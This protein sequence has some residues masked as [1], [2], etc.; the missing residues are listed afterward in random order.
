MISSAP[1]R[2]R[3]RSEP[4]WPSGLIAME[5]F[6]SRMIFPSKSTAGMRPWR[7][8]CTRSAPRPKKPFSTKNASVA[9]WFAWL[10]M[11][12]QCNGFP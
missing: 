11:M 1:L 3:A 4:P 9:A 5:D 12:N 6:V 10:V 2:S 7:K 8:K